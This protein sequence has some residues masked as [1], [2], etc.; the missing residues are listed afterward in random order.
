M[1]KQYL[2]AVEIT[3]QNTDRHYK[4]FFVTEAEEGTEIEDFN[5]KIMDIYNYDM[6][7]YLADS[8]YGH[9]YWLDICHAVHSWKEL[10]QNEF[11][12]LKK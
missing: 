3:D 6:E 10:P 2:V 7:N 5:K 11:K 8:N 9:F 1:K 4:D 12:V